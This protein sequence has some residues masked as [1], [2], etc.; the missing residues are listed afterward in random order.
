MALGTTR[1]VGRVTIEAPVASFRYPH[2]LIGRQPTFDMP[3][4][5]SVHG[6]VAAA[7]GEWPAFPVWFAYRFEF[8]S[9]VSDLEHQHIIERFTGTKSRFKEPDPLWRPPSEENARRARKGPPQ[10]P[11]IPTSTLMTVQPHLRDFLFDVSLLLYLDPPELAAAFHS[12]TFPLS[13]GRS[14]DLASVRRTETVRLVES[15][16]GYLDHTLL[17]IS[18]RGRISRGVTVLMPSYIG[19]PPERDAEFAPFIVLPERLLVGNAEP[20]G[21]RQNLRIAGTEESWLVDLDSP[22]FMNSHRALWFHHIT[23]P[24]MR[25]Q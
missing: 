12:P 9:R 19:P 10:P 21:E 8:R 2:F 20:E 1:T 13:L 17:P 14:Q 23:P 6:L 3:P 22:E 15:T 11:P 4:P 18:F 24:Q 25:E 5:S 16:G 7:L